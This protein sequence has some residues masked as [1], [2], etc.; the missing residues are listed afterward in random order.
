[1]LAFLIALVSA[2]PGLATEI[3]PEPVICARPA[4]GSE[5]GTHMRPKKR[6]MRKSDLDFVERYTRDTL[7]TINGRGNNPAVIPSGPAR[8]DPETRDPSP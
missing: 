6:C 2:E 4:I 3:Q 1:M 5:V 8:A 7:Q